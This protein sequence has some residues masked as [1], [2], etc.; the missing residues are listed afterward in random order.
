MSSMT[1]KKAK[2]T[3]WGVEFALWETGQWDRIWAGRTPG[4]T[5]KQLTKGAG[6]YVQ[7][8]MDGLKIAD[9]L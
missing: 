3:R 8:V 1:T 2:N 7:R 4:H 5:D 9:L 6:I